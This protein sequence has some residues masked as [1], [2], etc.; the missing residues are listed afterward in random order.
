[1]VLW[2]VRS[3]QAADRERARAD[4][5]RT[6]LIRTLAGAVATPRREAATLPLPA[7]RVL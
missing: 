2:A 1:V 7:L 5:D 6:L 3:R 4:L